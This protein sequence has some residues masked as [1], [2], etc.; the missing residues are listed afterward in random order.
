MSISAIL[1]IPTNQKLR[2]S[3]LVYL[4]LTAFC[5]VF[6]RVYCL[7]GDGVESIFVLWLFLCPLLGGRL[8]LG[9]LWILV[10]HAT[11][12]PLFRAA[13]NAFNTAMATL[14]LGSALSGVIEIAGT[15]SIYP[16]Y[17]LLVG[18]IIYTV[19]IGLY[20]LGL[21]LRKRNVT[22]KS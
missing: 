10:D 4:G 20:L 9:L 12:V 13:Y 1:K 17:F 14:L 6:D 2:K 19:S 16:P 21:L 8:P 5:I 11:E 18:W 3:L 7:L 22:K 15:A